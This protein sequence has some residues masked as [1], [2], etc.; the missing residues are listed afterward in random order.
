[1][2][3]RPN[4]TEQAGV[5]GLADLITAANGQSWPL[6]VKSLP[7]PTVPLDCVRPLAAARDRQLEGRPATNPPRQSTSAA[8]QRSLLGALLMGRRFRV[9]ARRGKRVRRPANNCA[10]SKGEASTAPSARAGA[11][12]N[13]RLKR[14][15]ALQGSSRG[16]NMG[17]HVRVNV[18]RAGGVP[19]HASGSSSQHTDG[20]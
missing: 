18:N 8:L 13:T 14:P 9:D 3:V 17:G 12:R 2:S 1:M 6:R 16:A 20:L 10:T 15:R 11:A 19:K 5:R 7:R 4:S